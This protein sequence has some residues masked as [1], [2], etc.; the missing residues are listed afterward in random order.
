MQITNVSKTFDL[1]SIKIWLILEKLL[2]PVQIL[3]ELTQIVANFGTV[4]WYDLA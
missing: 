3:F 4:L 2:I 1:V